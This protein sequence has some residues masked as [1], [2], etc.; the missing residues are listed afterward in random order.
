MCLTRGRIRFWI[1]IKIE[2]ALIRIRIG[3]KAMPIYNTGLIRHIPSSVLRFLR[4]IFL[5][6][7][8][9]Q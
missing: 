3:F 6:T 9:R 2:S 8:D 5:F 4:I 7:I 1:G